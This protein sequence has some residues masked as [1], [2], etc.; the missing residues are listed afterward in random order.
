MITGIS[1]TFILKNVLSFI[2]ITNNSVNSINSTNNKIKL[3][4]YD[5][6]VDSRILNYLVYQN[7]DT[8]QLVGEIKQ[9]DSEVL[10]HFNKL[11]ILYMNLE[12]IMRFL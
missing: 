6:V 10:N 1:D 4:A 12:H 9:I 11:S 3:F 8:V 5:I 7:I 2:T